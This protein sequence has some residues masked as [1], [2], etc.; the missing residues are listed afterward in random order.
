MIDVSHLQEIK[1][2]ELLAQD[3]L[4]A[5]LVLERLLSRLPERSEVIRIETFN[6]VG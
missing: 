2:G 4:R 1:R 3:K 5:N 6:S